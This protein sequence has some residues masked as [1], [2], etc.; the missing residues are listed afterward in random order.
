MDIMNPM[1]ARDVM[2]TH[3]YGEVDIAASGAVSAATQT[4]YGFTVTRTAQGDYRCTLDRAYPELLYADAQLLFVTRTNGQLVLK[5]RDMT[6]RTVDF[7]YNAAGVAADPP[8][9]SKIY[10]QLVLKDSAVAP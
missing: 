1:Q 10:I 7:F 2:V 4:S 5:A 6:A 9:G 8:S 3:L